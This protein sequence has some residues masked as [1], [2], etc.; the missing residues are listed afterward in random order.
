MY[1]APVVIRA[2]AGG[3]GVGLVVVVM[4]LALYYL[5]TAWATEPGILPF[6]EYIPPNDDE[7]GDTKGEGGGDPDGE[8]VLRRNKPERKRFAIIL[9]G[10]QLPL[11][12]S[13]PCSRD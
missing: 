11:P 10:Q 3:F 4:T 9:N 7:L 12:V 13:I 6:Q 1:V 8:T 5:V 2:P